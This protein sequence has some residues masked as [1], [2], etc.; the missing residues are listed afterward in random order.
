M[1]DQLFNLSDFLRAI[2]S[3][4]WWQVL[5]ELLI[6]GAVVYWVISFLQGTRGARLLKGIVVL[7][8]TLYVVVKLLAARFGL[9]RVEYLYGRFLLAAGFAIIVV[10]QPELRRAL[11]RLGETR[12]FGDRSRQLHDDIDALVEGIER[13]RKF[14]A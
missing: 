10:F 11:M 9:Q 7:L 8:I 3:Y 12:L 14:F 4:P 2:N 1:N 13:A 6:I 5:I